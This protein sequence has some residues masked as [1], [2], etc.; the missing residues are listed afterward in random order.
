MSDVAALAM[1]R[2][3]DVANVRNVSMEMAGMRC[4]LY[5]ARTLRM[6]QVVILQSSGFACRTASLVC[7]P[8]LLGAYCTGSI[9]IK[10]TT[11]VMLRRMRQAAAVRKTPNPSQTQR[12]SM[13]EGIF[14]SSH[15]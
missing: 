9:R 3:G 5:I 13:R 10:A 7:C 1:L 8:S 11:S 2:L 15:P 14:L 12:S 6:T 4:Q